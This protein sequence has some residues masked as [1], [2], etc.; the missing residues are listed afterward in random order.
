MTTNS[1]QKN[2]PRN[3]AVGGKNGPLGPVIQYIIKQI[4]SNEENTDR[5]FG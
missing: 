4:S 2:K 3:R 5:I 1:W